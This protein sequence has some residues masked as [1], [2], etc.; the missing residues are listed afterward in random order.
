MAVADAFK[1]LK[2]EVSLPV[3]LATVGVVYATFSVIQPNL[4]DVKASE[5]NHPDLINGDTQAL[6]LATGICGAISLLSGDITPFILG[7]MTAVLLTW[8][9]RHARALDPITGKITSGSVAGSVSM[10]DNVLEMPDARS[11]YSA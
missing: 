10:G 4:A 2:P 11:A 5:P 1:G 3:S 9:Y 6:A 8:Y 7:G